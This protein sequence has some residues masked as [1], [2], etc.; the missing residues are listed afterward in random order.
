MYAI[1]QTG[2]KQYKVAVGDEVL[3][4]KLDAADGSEVSIPA[5]AVVKGD[6]V[7]ANPKN[8][9]KAVVVETGRGPKLTI[10]KYKAK[11]NYRRK[12]GHRQ[13]FTRIKITA[14]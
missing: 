8:A 10:F 12:Q 11:K 5:V 13:P 6:A 7:E 1:I 3:V 14:I 2:G 4:E 9:V